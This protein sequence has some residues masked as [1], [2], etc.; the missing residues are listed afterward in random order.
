MIDL[1]PLDVRKKRGD[2][3]NKLRGYDPQE[4]DTF[5]EDVAMRFEELV[6]ENL[7]LRDRTEMLQERVDASDGR[8]RAVQEALVTAQE[9]RADVTK[10]AKREADLIEREA[11]GRIDALVADA[12][13]HLKDR[14]GAL[15]ELERKRNKF[16]KSFRTFLEREMDSV[17]VE[18]GRA[19]LDDMTVDLDLGGAW[20][21][22]RGVAGAKDDGG[23]VDDL[24]EPEVAGE[25]ETRAAD[26]FQEN[27][28]ELNEPTAERAVDGSEKDSGDP[29]DEASDKKALWLYDLDETD[30]ERG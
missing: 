30:G 20:D 21:A 6:K 29:G 19:P 22:A 16:L 4:V 11:R 5:L 24:E 12:E 9:L 23:V 13:R 17:E 15:D 7:R 14:V 26:G 28:A 2:F 8:E 27:S 25:R 18:E 10:Q 1:T 3:S